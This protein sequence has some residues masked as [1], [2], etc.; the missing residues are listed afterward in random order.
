MS[1]ANGVVAAAK[2]AEGEAAAKAIGKVADDATDFDPIAGLIQ[3]I[4]PEN[5][6]A[7]GTAGA[8][9]IDST[10]GLAVGSINATGNVISA[11]TGMSV[12]TINATG[13]IINTAGKQIG[14]V[15]KEAMKSLTTL[16]VSIV[17]AA[18]DVAVS[19]GKNI[20]QDIKGAQTASTKK[21]M[22]KYIAIGVVAF[23]IAII[24]I[25]AVVV[26]A[27][28]SFSLH[29]AGT[30]TNSV[31]DAETPFQSWRSPKAFPYKENYSFEE[32]QSSIPRLAPAQV[33]SSGAS[34][35]QWM[36][37]DSHYLWQ[38]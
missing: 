21:K 16:G 10:T 27:K 24:I 38:Q 18:R 7:L 29:S 35:G 1:A 17:G 8:Q 11:A 37:P 33:S 14:E 15:T 22:Y 2:A 34:S 32:M 5:L 23:L 3:K 20:T 36:V 28:K 13:K 25:V 4:N 26:G 31:Y 12:G 19:W 30:M 9:L 6:K